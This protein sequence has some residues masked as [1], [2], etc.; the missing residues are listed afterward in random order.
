[1]RLLVDTPV[2]SVNV[3]VAQLSLISPKSR[4]RTV[5]EV[6][7]YVL[8]SYR[9]DNRIHRIFQRNNSTIAHS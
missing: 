5:D 9:I 2:G 8:R 1:M 4:S 7:K 3:F 6:G